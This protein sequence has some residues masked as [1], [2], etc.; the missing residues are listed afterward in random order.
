MAAAAYREGRAGWMGRVATG[1]TVAGTAL[2]ATLGG[3]YR[4]AAAGAGLALLAG[5]V[6][7]RFAVMQAGRQ[8]AEDPA[9]T[10]EPQRQRLAERA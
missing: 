2:G 3:R 8:S 5:G 4:P 1:L 9:Q 6:L 10:V 7:R